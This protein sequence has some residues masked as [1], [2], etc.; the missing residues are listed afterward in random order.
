MPVRTI[1]M[2]MPTFAVSAWRS[3]RA[4]TSASQ[5]LPGGSSS[6]TGS[7]PRAP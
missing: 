2:R 7:L 4:V 1:T 3:Q 6:S 5:S